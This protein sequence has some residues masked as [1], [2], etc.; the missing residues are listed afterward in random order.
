MIRITIKAAA[1]ASVLLFGAGCGGAP[2]HEPEL[3][4]GPLGGSVNTAGSIGQQPPPDY[5]AAAPNR[6]HAVDGDTILC[7]SSEKPIVL[8]RITYNMPVG[9]VQAVRAEVRT[10]GSETTGPGEKTPIAMLTG[11]IGD[12]RYGSTTWKL[13]GKMDPVRG[14]VIKASCKEAYAATAFDE[15]MI[16]IEAGTEGAWIRSF[17]IHYHVGKS[18]YRAQ[19]KWSSGL[20]GT[21]VRKLCS[22]PDN[23][24]HAAKECSG[25][26]S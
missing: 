14:H 4:G 25:A 7:A 5:K 24:F 8:D 9:S 16:Q 6:W 19:V 20:M 3:K 10:V 12:Y 15:L 2:L 11:T 17:T 22:D 18:R 26:H 13:A 23:P 21:G 1:V